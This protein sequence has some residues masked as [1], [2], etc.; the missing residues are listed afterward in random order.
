MS[1]L[2]LANP[3]QT[4]GFNS[5]TT[6]T[7]IF[8]D[9][10]RP[11]ELADPIPPQESAF[12]LELDSHRTNELSLTTPI[13]IITRL[14]F[15]WSRRYRNA[16]HFG[17]VRIPLCCRELPGFNAIE[18]DLSSPALVA[19]VLGGHV[20]GGPEREVADLYVVCNHSCIIDLA[21][22]SC[23]E[24]WPQG[25]AY[26][27]SGT[28]GGGIRT[29]RRLP[30]SKGRAGGG[31]GAHCSCERPQL[32]ARWTGSRHSPQPPQKRKD[33]YE[34]QASGQECRNPTLTQKLSHAHRVSPIA[35]LNDR[36]VKP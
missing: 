9:L 34:C 24:I 27:L 33:C 32:V 5:T 3:G 7:A 18:R 30:R 13:G 22:K 29:R 11:V 26:R 23:L 1:D 36:K 17:A 14:P 20:D 6:V 15:F 4:C 2:G 8:P 35:P 25:H 12:V 19:V 16:L 10:E 31:N 28:S 21:D